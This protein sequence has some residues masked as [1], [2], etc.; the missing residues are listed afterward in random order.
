MHR[1]TN[2]PQHHDVRLGR[3]RASDSHQGWIVKTRNQPTVLHRHQR[4]GK[5]I[6]NVP[7]GE[8][9]LSAADA[10]AIDEMVK[11]IEEGQQA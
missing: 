2:D 10:A 11:T 6:E 9:R 8:A 5:I 3:F 4:V 1:G 7:V